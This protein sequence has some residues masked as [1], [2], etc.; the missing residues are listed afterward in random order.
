[1]A[2]ITYGNPTMYIRSDND[3]PWEKVNGIGY[4]EEAE[5]GGDTFD[6][7]ISTCSYMP[8][9]GELSFDSR[10]YAKGSNSHAEGAYTVAKGM[11]PT[12]DGMNC[13]AKITASD[14]GISNQVESIK[15]CIEDLKSR[16][17][18]LEVLPKRATGIR[19]ALKTLQYKSE[20]E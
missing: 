19:S 9:Q 17:S 18:A 1:M 12:F 8:L 4:T 5:F 7:S 13:S 3:S 6:R 16:L 20:V 15:D 11:A 14:F 2:K 10:T